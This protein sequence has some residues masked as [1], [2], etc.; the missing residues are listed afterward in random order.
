MEIIW[1]TRM[2]SRA[3]LNDTGKKQMAFI[4]NQT[5]GLARTTDEVEYG[6][7]RIWVFTQGRE[8][9]LSRH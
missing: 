3:C 8:E 6:G 1:I 7:L 2:W 5:E 4:T 9:G